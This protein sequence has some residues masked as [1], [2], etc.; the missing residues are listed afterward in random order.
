MQIQFV[1][2]MQSL[3]VKPNLDFSGW[4]WPA[5]LGSASLTTVLVNRQLASRICEVDMSSAISIQFLLHIL[6]HR[7]PVVASSFT[8][9]IP[10]LCYSLLT[11]VAYSSVFLNGNGVL[12]KFC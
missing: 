9:S 7:S 6:F 5:R 8:E 1:V 12:A 10:D 2:F 11:S 4:L 3:L